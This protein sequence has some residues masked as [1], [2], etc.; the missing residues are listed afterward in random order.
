M[1]ES[2]LS[3]DCLSPASLVGQ[4]EAA[5]EDLRTGMGPA[6]DA[7]CVHVTQRARLF[8]RRKYRVA[9]FQTLTVQS[10]PRFLVLRRQTLLHQLGINVGHRQSFSALLTS[11]DAIPR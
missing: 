2:Y 10:G 5:H 1:E 3:K 11:I 8:L 9:C 4:D 7:P 6:Q